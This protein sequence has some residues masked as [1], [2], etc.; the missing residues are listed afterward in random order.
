MALTP[1]AD[2]VTE[3]I[4]SWCGVTSPTPA[5]LSVATMAANAAKDAIKYYR[6]L[7][8]AEPW[9]PLTTYSLYD[10]VRPPGENTGHIYTATTAGTSD[11]TRPTFPTTTGGTVT[12]GTVVWTEDTPTFETTYTTLAIEIGVYLYQ[13]RGADGAVAFGENGVQR[14]FEKGSIPPSMLSRITPRATT[15]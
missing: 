9:Q 11:S 2:D 13:K 1:I 14:S 12:D 4:L 8:K 15:G 3:G 5:Q 10:V 6:G 7:L